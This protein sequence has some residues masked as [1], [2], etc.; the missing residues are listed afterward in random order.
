[1]VSVELDVARFDDELAAL[2]HGVARVDGH[3]DDCALEL[4]GIGPGQPNDRGRATWTA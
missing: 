2:R 1:M 3:V 4:T